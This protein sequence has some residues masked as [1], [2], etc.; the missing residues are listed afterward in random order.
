MD[1]FLGKY[2]DNNNNILIAKKTLKYYNLNEE[3]K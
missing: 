1:F 3:S 2:S